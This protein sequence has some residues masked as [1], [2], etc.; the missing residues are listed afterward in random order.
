MKIALFQVMMLTALAATASANTNIVADPMLM[1]L[2]KEPAFQRAFLGSYGMNAEV[3]PS[4]T[5]AEREL[6]SQL[7]PM[8]SA[9][10][11]KAAA[12]LKPQVKPESSALLDYTLGN[13]YFQQDRLDKAIVHFRMA[14]AK[15]PSFRRAWRNLGL[16]YTRNSH[17]EDSIRAFTTA[18]SLGGADAYLFGLLAYAYAA[19]QDYPAAEAAYRNALVFQPDSMEWRM[20]LCRA[21]F[22][23]GKFEEA[24]SLLEAMIIRQPDRAEFWIL[25]ANAYVGM[26]KT[27]KAADN[28]VVVAMLG[29]ATP[30]TLQMLGDIYVS[31]QLPALAAEAYGQ[32]LRADAGGAF[33][34]DRHVQNVETLA[35]RGAL[36]EADALRQSVVET[37]G[38]NLSAQAQ[39]RLLRIQAKVA[40]SKGQGTSAA[41]VL[42]EALKLNPLD[43]DVLMLLAQYY[44]GA[45][46]TEKACLYYERAAGIERYEADARLRQAQC[47]VK[48]NRY[49]EAA[50]LLKRVQELRPRE[51]VARY[52]EQVERLA[53]A[54]N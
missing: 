50:P 1:R 10:L 42:E 29:K 41:Q 39:G 12:F 40:I 14:V 53:R 8:M 44:A 25:Q 6:M 38:T 49:Q 15:Y 11:G 13:I 18:I 47:L 43:G 48:N 27:L 34:P 31:E 30:E 33:K 22:K 45:G 32:A 26:K 3:E 7:L 19:Q 52:L 23:Q 21:A 35:G 46:E 20:G 16:I 2:W 17:F 24:A 9:N 51:D 37:A 4:A 36:A 54:K 28:L 5:S